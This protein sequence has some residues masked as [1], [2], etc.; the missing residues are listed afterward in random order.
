MDILQPLQDAL[1]TFL[2][3]LPQLVG[4]IVILIIGYIVR[5]AAKASLLG[6]FSLGL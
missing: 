1:S 4:A 5:I 6:N 3:F 2:S